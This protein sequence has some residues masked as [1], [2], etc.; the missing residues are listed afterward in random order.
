MFLRTQTFLQMN[1]N[2][3]GE[4][5]KF[6]QVNVKFFLGGNA[7]VLQVSVNFLGGMQKFCK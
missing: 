7:K 4:N 6:L 1:V 2:F 3:F 5:A